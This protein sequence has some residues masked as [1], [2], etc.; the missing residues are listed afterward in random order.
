MG[1]ARYSLTFCEDWI[2]SR[3]TISMQTDI[4]DKRYLV[5]FVVI[6]RVEV[7]AIDDL[8]AEREGFNRLSLYEKACALALNVLP[9]TEPSP[10][11][12]PLD[13]AWKYAKEKFETIDRSWVG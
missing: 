3:P 6:H 2:A 5:E 11:R 9:A 8:Q 1:V 10:T 4:T 13:V 7:S 12:S